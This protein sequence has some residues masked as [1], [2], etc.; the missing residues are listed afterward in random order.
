MRAEPGAKKKSSRIAK[1]PAEIQE[2]RFAKKR[3]DARESENLWGWQVPNLRLHF[4]ICFL[5]YYIFSFP[6]FGACL[7]FERYL[8]I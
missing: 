6:N 5:L 4:A 7:G 2:L 1:E 8:G 3:G